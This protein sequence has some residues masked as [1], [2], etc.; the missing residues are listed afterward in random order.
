MREDR[1][2]VYLEAIDRLSHRSRY[3]SS[4]RYGILTAGVYPFETFRGKDKLVSP[5]FPTLNP[6]AEQVLGAGRSA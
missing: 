2:F 4:F 3:V 1:D 6:T 5:T